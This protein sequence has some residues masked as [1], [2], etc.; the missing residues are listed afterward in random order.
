MSKRS[1]VIE[2]K[3]VVHR[4][5]NG[6]LVFIERSRARELVATHDALWSAAETGSGLFAFG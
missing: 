6:E 1:D 2:A 5:V 4:A 3:E